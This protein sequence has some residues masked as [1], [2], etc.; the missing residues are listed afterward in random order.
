MGLTHPFILVCNQYFFLNSC[1]LQPEDS[2]DWPERTQNQTIAS[3][4]KPFVVT[5]LQPSSHAKVYFLFI[6]ENNVF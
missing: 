2:E 4:N 6:V 5:P 1:F 3:N